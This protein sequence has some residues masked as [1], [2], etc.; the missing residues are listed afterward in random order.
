MK[1]IAVIIPAFNEEKS[2]GKVL[3][4]IQELK[5]E[6]DFS[7]TAVVVND[8]STDNTISEAKKY[9]CVVLE[10]P[11]NLG[12]GGAVQT[13]FIYAYEK[14]FDFALQL[15][16]DGQHPPEEISKFIDYIKTNDA[17]VVVGSR[18]ITNEGF[19]STF[20]RRLGIFYFKF[21]IRLLCG[22]TI[23]DCTSG[24]RMISRRVLEVVKDNYPDEY[25]EPE[26]IVIYRKYKFKIAEIPVTMKSRDGGQSSIRS[27]GSLYYM[28]KVSLAIVFTFMKK[29]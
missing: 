21:L 18:F 9:P 2:I 8:C 10:L 14:G 6:A 27:F 25:P 12:I 15:D 22:I 1:K 26:A 29:I 3:T 13:G 11:V 17:D 5:T 23:T 16:G 24:F 28:V 19:R 4:K 20:F 7:L